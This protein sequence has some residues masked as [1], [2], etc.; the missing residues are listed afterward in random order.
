MNLRRDKSAVATAMAGQA[1]RECIR[2]R[3]GYSGQGGERPYIPLHLI[4]AGFVARQR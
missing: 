1:T 2:R 4:G 3:Q